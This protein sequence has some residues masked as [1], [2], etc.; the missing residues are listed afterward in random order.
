MNNL[1]RH[2]LGFFVVMAVIVAAHPAFG[3]AHKGKKVYMITDME[4]VDGVFNWADQCRPFVSPR[5]SES[6]KLLTGEVNAAVE[7]LYAGGATEVVVA[8]LH[9]DSRSLSTLTLDRRARLL[10]GHD[11]PPTLGL[12]RSY[13]A[14]IFIGQHAMAGAKNGVISHSYSFSI[15][16][17]WINNIRVGE[18]GARTML[19]GYYGVPVIMLAGDQAACKEL[20]ALVP[21]ARCATVKWGFSWSAGISLSHKAACDLIQ[22]KARDA[23]EHLAEFKPYKIGGPVEVKVEHT[24]QSMLGYWPQKGVERLNE[25]TDVY[26]GK[27]LV[28]AWLKFSSF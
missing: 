12:D 18:I 26:R 19:A 17:I 9:D 1:R 13:S 7:G 11:T 14:V 27:D 4:G 3:Q 10:T 23:M 6:Q 21:N 20:R 8:D 22:E 28:D 15:Q 5:W 24:V 16:N 2:L 25:R